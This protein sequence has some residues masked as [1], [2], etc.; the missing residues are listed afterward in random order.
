MNGYNGTN[1][2]P[3]PQGPPGVCCCDCN[4]ENKHLHCE[5]VDFSVGRWTL[6]DN[7]YVPNG[8]F[9]LN[10]LNRGFVYSNMVD[11]QNMPLLDPVPEVSSRDASFVIGNCGDDATVTFEFEGSNYTLGPHRA[12]PDAPDAMPAPVTSWNTDSNWGFYDSPFNADASKYHV[13]KS[14]VLGQDVQIINVTFEPSTKD[15]E[16][17]IGGIHDTGVVCVPLIDSDDNVIVIDPEE[18]T[19]W[20][21]QNSGIQQTLIATFDAANTAD[22]NNA[23]IAFYAGET[24]QV[25]ENTLVEHSGNFVGVGFKLASVHAKKLIISYFD[26]DEAALQAWL[27]GDRSTEPSLLPASSDQE[28]PAGPFY[29]SPVHVS[30]DL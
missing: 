10:P 21:V 2:Q 15:L 16:F 14:D 4:D 5:W 7:E 17:Y 6:D 29:L 30:F 13:L 22:L 11:V 20:A 9:P 27:Q 8:V 28:A 24:I 3:G 19:G 25:V 23:G 12:M 18:M 1:G 26:K